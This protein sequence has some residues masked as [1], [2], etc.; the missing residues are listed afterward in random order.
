M[1]ETKPFDARSAIALDQQGLPGRLLFAG[2]FVGF[3]L[4][5]L[6]WTFVAGWVVAILVWEFASAPFLARI[7]GLRA[8]RA[9]SIFAIANLIGSSIFALSPVMALAT[10]T[11]IG[12]AIGATWFCGAFMNCFIYAGEHR[13]LLWA[14]LAPSIIA[15]VVGP[16]LL[17]GPSVAGGVIS[18]LILTSLIAAKSFSIDHQVLLRRLAD[19]QGALADVERKLA[20]AVEASGDGLFEMDLQAQTSEVSAG[21]RAMLGYGPDDHVNPILS[22]YV[23]PDDLRALDAEYLAHLRGETPH[24]ASELRLRCADGSYKWVLSRARLVSRSAD[25]RPWRMV[26]TTVNI[27]ARKALEHQLETAVEVAERANAAKDVFV[28][29]MSHE[30]RTPL[31]GVI[32]ITG[33]LA[34]TAL[35]AQQREMV[36]I[37]QSSAQVLERLLSDI[38]DQSKLD[39]GEFELQ[40]APFDLREAIESATE[41]LRP[42]AFEKGV[43][44][45]ISYAEAAAGA[46]EGDAVRLRQIVSNL[47]ANAIKFTEAGSVQIMVEAED[48]SDAELASVTIRVSDTGIG[49]DAETSRR[50][51]ARFVQ[52]DGSIS[53]RFGGT[54]LGL[55]IC[56]TLTERMGGAITARSE[57]GAGSVF[58]VML[59]LRRVSRDDC[60]LADAASADVCDDEGGLEGLHGLRILLA[61]DHPTNQR[62]VQLILDSVGVDLT[63]VGDGEAAIEAFERSPLDLILMDMQMPGVDGLAATREIRRREAGGSRIPIAMLT[64]N[65]TDEHR[66]MAAAAGATHHIAKPI[67][68]QSLF[69][70]IA[71]AMSADPRPVPAPR[72]AAG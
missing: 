19:K 57:P 39:A 25:G 43:D 8:D 58:E 67:T 42:R 64:A 61:E 33:A 24:T 54:G 46:F 63:I 41:L 50:L 3:S 51:F 49:F 32:G 11:P 12:I 52:A 31:N 34:R 40:A 65:A 21:W 16:M 14:T 35:T 23:H 4:L 48:A 66:D 44:F 36:G 70:G 71:A 69:A 18:T 30:I 10:L 7:V 13:K 2:L 27:A 28:A 26:G 60:A 29:N 15:S 5:V 38:L 68:P 1:S 59:P 62:V 45:R 47:A 37:V 6:P 72:L 22:E 53:R 20:I 55:A 9:L 56:K 17:H